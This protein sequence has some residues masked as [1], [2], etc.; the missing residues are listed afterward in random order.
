M[1]KRIVT[2][3]ILGI[4]LTFTFFAAVNVYAEDKTIGSIRV[5]GNKAISTSTILNRIK[6][7]PG[8][9]FDEG[10]VN[11]EIKRLYATGYFA[12]VFAEVNERPEGME[13]FFT[14]V[15]KPIVKQIEFQ[16]NSRIPIRKLEKKITLKTGVLLDYNILSQDVAEIT[17]FY[18]QEGYS[19]VNVDYRIDTEPDTGEAIIVFVIDEGF[20]RKIRSIVI[21][22]NKNISDEELRKYMTTKKAFFFIQKGSYNQEKLDSDLDRLEMLYRSKGFLDAQ[23]RSKLDTS[24]DGA[25]IFITVVVN[26]GQ[27]YLV[28]QMEINGDLSFPE[29]EIRSK[30]KIRP[31]DPFDYTQIKEDVEN[32]R[33]FYY[34]YGYMD[35]DVDL[36]HKYDSK[37]DRMALDFKVNSNN[38]I[39]VGKVNILGNTKTKDKVV[40]RE[41]RVYPGERYDGRK[42]KKSKERIYNLGFFEDVY[43]ETIPTDDPNVKDLNVTIKETKTG[44]LSFGGGYSSVDSFIG[45]AQVSQKN[46]DILNFPS[47]TGGGQNLTIRGEIGSTKTNYFLS[48]T[49]PW[50]FDLPFL[51]GADL[52]REEHDRD[53]TSGWDYDEMRMGGSL[54][55]GKELTDEWST[56][57]IYNLEEVKISNI[58]DDSSDDL[59]AEI[60]KNYISRLTWNLQYDSRDNKYSPRKGWLI[61]SM[62]ENAGGFLAGDKDFIKGSGVITYYHTF[63][64]IF[65]LE[66]KA[67][68]GIVKEYGDS[69]TVPIYERLF[70]GG[71][72][73]I[74][75]YK[76]RAVGP[77]DSK[78]TSVAVGGR[79]RVIGNAEV[80][81][82][83]FKNLIK[84]AV[85][86][87]VGTV[88]AKIEDVTKADEYKAGAGIGVRVKTPIGPV[89]L[90]WGYPLNSNW[91]EKKE[92][93]FY[94]SVSHGF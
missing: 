6:I 18:M 34:D 70:A 84:G 46:F 74:R 83:I 43:L 94:F 47:F 54:R 2:L 23:V 38:I 48:W 30:I 65:V 80:N 77:R 67:R 31:G 66:L 9:A 79:A 39:S 92:G 40:R 51:F 22:G 10:A 55:L 53:S 44:E 26:E 5:Q 35:A 24:E 72:T 93:Q 78:D 33:T 25:N 28:G 32:I 85:F 71:A 37:E 27:R 76:Q 21:Q 42:L 50:I 4:F 1:K 62:L 8:E 3:L 68:A 29:P 11:K 88:T 63:F 13:V 82:P 17:N 12:D 15:E 45:F 14:V 20:P 19:R 86:Y 89:K 36:R 81:F 59:K 69:K 87:D 90:D 75:G 52:Y 57:V 7:K 56:G 60:G 64:D 73:T 16:G 91:N 49:D 58:P 61:G 41:I